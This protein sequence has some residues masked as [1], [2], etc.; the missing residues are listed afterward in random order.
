MQHTDQAPHLLLNQHLYTTGQVAKLLGVDESTLRRW[1]R[2][3]PIQGPGFIH[4]SQRVVMYP[5]DDLETYLQSRH[6]LPSA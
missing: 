6:V 2:A 5:A 1:R 4:L 3:T